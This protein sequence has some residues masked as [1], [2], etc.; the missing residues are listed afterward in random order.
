MRLSAPNAT[1]RTDGKALPAGNA[2]RSGDQ[3]AIE[4]LSTDK[5]LADANSRIAALE[6]NLSRLEQMLE[7]RDREPAAVQQAATPSVNPSAAPT[8]TEP[9]KDKPAAPA[10]TGISAAASATPFDWN[11]VLHE[12]LARLLA[13]AATLLVLLALLLRLRSR[14]SGGKQVRKRSK[15]NLV[16][17]SNG[18][19]PAAAVSG[20]RSAVAAE[21]AVPATAAVAAQ[22]SPAAQP[23]LSALDCAST[24]AVA[25][26]HQSGA[27]EVDAIAEADVYI[28]YGRDEQA[29]EILR[30]ALRAQPLRDAL[31]V[32]LL[33][34]YA[35]RRDRQRFGE[36]AAELYAVTAGRGGLW[37]Q[38]AQM[39]QLLDPGNSLYGSLPLSASNAP[40]ALSSSPTADKPGA[41]SGAKSGAA[42]PV[43]DFGLKLEGLLDE[44][45]REQG[46]PPPVTQALMQ[47]PSA[48]AA[49][50]F[51][52]S[53][54]ARGDTS[55]QRIEPT[56]NGQPD[57]AVL[58][59]KF[60]LAVACEE[61]G[62]HE[63]AREL[64]AEVASARDPEL[65]R[66]AQD[67][68]RKLA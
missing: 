43:D 65:S 40:A 8:A 41:N 55:G 13:A 59:T 5:A 10:E 19:A 48:A 26:T 64:L 11:D 57:P 50:D 54:I 62:D 33:E 29:E 58:T 35:A 21:A 52:L 49:P 15:V 42:S 60:D 32:K 31:R 25:G 9:P 2:G 47:P 39:G 17:S 37:E 53:G 34:I 16:G 46:K 44:Q 61:I 12:P 27:S 66:R 4:Q 56:L 24:G 67:M 1:S 36:L 51:S 45:R 38:A 30:D 3:R 6:K 14:R 7:V 63:G 68:L 18:Q 28:A 23:V 20:A 22:A